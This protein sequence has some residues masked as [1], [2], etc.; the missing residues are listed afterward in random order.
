[1]CGA[2]SCF[3]SNRQCLVGS[4]PRVRSRP[5]QP[6]TRNLPLGIISA[7]AE[8]TLVPGA[9][10]RSSTDHLRVC[11]A[12]SSA[13]SSPPLRMGS[14]PRVRSRRQRRDERGDRTGIISACAEQTCR[15]RAASPRDR[16][17]L[18]VCGA[19]TVGDEI[20]MPTAGSSPRVRSRR[21]AALSRSRLCGIISACAEQT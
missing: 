12:D 3:W 9:T 11:G 10:R 13:P 19:D 2:D 15:T 8:Q 7:C 20:R 16:D 1:M 6:L 5:S 18:R 21:G 4:S 17:H 14:S